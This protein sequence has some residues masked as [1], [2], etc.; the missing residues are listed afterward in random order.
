LEE[1]LNASGGFTDALEDDVADLQKIMGMGVREAEELRS[2]IVTKTYKC[3]IH[4]YY[5]SW[6][7]CYCCC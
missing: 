5:S 4:T 6:H 7:P 1:S 2:E 3:A